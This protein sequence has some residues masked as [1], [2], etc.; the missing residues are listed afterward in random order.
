MSGDGKLR[1]SEVLAFDFLETYFVRFATTFFIRFFATTGG[2]S[3]KGNGMIVLH[4]A[5]TDCNTKSKRT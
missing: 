2:F 3:S 1:R 4:W 5:I